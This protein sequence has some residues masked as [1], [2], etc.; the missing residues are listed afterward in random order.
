MTGWQIAGAVVG[1]LVV[2]G[3]L[4]VV[5]GKF[6]AGPPRPTIHEGATQREHDDP[7][8]AAWTAPIVDLGSLDY[9]TP[10][11]ES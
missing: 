4:G 3:C 1:A 8:L 11:G 6:A 2:S 9:R 10:G 5:V 7:V